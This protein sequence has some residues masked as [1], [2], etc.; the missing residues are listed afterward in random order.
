MAVVSTE[1]S[2]IAA[3]SWIF[4]IEIMRIALASRSACLSVSS[5]PA[6]KLSGLTQAMCSFQLSTK[7]TIC[8]V[9]VPPAASPRSARPIICVI[10]MVDTVGRVKKTVLVCGRST[11]SVSIITLTRTFN[12]PSSYAR[13]FRSLSSWLMLAPVNSSR[14]ADTTKSAGIPALLKSFDSVIACTTLTAKT[15]VCPYS[16]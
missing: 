4:L 16:S 13:I 10:K 7:D 1:S 15:S 6:S 2:M 9:A 11:P 5:P 14:I 12:L 3:N 8:A